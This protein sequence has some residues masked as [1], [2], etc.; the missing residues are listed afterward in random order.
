MLFNLFPKPFNLNVFSRVYANTLIHS[1]K[2][3]ILSGNINLKHLMVLTQKQEVHL[4]WFTSSVCFVDVVAWSVWTQLP[5]Q[6]SSQVLWQQD[7]KV[8]NTETEKVRQRKFIM[9]WTQVQHQHCCQPE[10]WVACRDTALPLQRALLEGS[11]LWDT[12]PSPNPDR[13]IRHIHSI[14]FGLPGTCPQLTKH[15][16]ALQTEQAW[17]RTLTLVLSWSLK[18]KSWLN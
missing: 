12:Q 10:R 14:D 8:P 1:L 16:P 11:S 9:A 18:A 17:S 15:A 4:T 3:V 7:S 13:V 6:H 5:S 2:P